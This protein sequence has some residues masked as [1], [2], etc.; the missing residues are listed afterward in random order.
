MPETLAALLKRQASA[1]TGRANELARLR[2][3][4]APDGPVVAYVHGLVGVGKTTLLHAFAAEA[5]AAGATTVELDGHVVYS[6]QASVL[7]ALAGAEA[8]LEE[9]AAAVGARGERVVVIVDTYELLAMVDH[10]MCR[11]LIP[12]LP[13]HVRVVLAGRDIPTD[14]WRS[15]GPL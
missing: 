14:R 2:R 9:A 12:A 3:L 10:W 1:I 4:L 15:Y 11:T 13:S 6:T 5:R 8:S 7:A